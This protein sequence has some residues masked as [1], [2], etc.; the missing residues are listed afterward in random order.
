MTNLSSQAQRDLGAYIPSWIAYQMKARRLPGAAAL[1]AYE[2]TVLSLSA[3]GFANLESAAPLTT[4]HYHRI[5]SH[6]KMFTATAIMQ[7]VES[8]QLRLD[9]P[10]TNWLPWLPDGRGYS[11]VTIRDLLNHTSGILRD[12]LDSDFWA[13]DHPFPAADDLQRLLNTTPL[14]FAPNEHFKYSNVGYGLLGLIVAAASGQ[15][16]NDYVASSILTPL[17]MRQTG[18]DFVPAVEQFMATG[19]SAELPGSTRRALAHVGTGAL[20]A[21]TGFY[22]TLEDMFQFTQA[23]TFGSSRLLANASKRVMQHPSWAIAGSP[24]RYGLG[25]YSDVAGGITHV[26]HSGGFPGFTT[27]TRFD[28]VDGH[29]AIAFVNSTNGGAEELTAGML[30]LLGYTL[31]HP[32]ESPSPASQV[33]AEAYSGRFAG[34]FQVRDV[35]SLAGHLISIH[36]SESDPLAALVTLTPVGEGRLRIKDD[37]GYGSRGEDVLYEFDAKGSAASIRW[38]GSTLI[39]ID[40]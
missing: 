25:F 40:D 4:A 2:G 18:P 32:S 15:P 20:S 17:G 33:P 29:V 19:Y 37:S 6:S 11:G 14:I 8:S 16:Y 3:H 28:P 24:Q 27:S 36:P 13:L 22:S 31:E 21:A 39:R 34:H 26:G 9:D 5:A 12:G 7:L 38:A 35:L 30:A 23:H 1:L 10:I